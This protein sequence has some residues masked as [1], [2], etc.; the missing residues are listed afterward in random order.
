M[1]IPLSIFTFQRS[2]P[3]NSDKN[4]RMFNIFLFLSWKMS[5]SSY[6]TVH[7]FISIN[8]ADWLNAFPRQMERNGGQ[9]HSTSPWNYSLKQQKCLANPPWTTFFNVKN[10]YGHSMLNSSPY[11]KWCWWSNLNQFKVSIY[12]C[13]HLLKY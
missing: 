4:S 5:S 13:V 7:C 2:K 9:G 8:L 11:S 3:R 1:W 6:C 10:N 12:F